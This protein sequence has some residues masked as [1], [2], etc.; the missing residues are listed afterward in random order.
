MADLELTELHGSLT[1]PALNSMNFLNEVSHHYPDA[2]SLAAGRPT[3]EFFALEDL[4]RYLDLFAD[5]LRDDRGTTRPRCGGRIFQYGRTKGIIHDLVARNLAVDEDIHVDPEAIVV[6]VGCQEAMFL[7]LRA[8]RADPDDVLLAVS[9][10]YVGLTGA[11]RLVDLPVLP[12]AGGA[13][14]V[15][16]DDLAAVVKA[17]RADGLRPRACY[18]MPD[19]ANPSGLSLGPGPPAA[20]AGARGRG[21]PAAARGQPVRPVPG[22]GRRPRADAEGAGHRAPGRLPRLVRQDRSA[23]R[24]G[25]LRRR[26]PARRGTGRQRSDCSPTN[27]RRSRAWSP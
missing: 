2:I 8:L 5:H 21:G 12:V 25:R 11:A 4:H 19:F 15:D 13:D 18:V 7:V 22:R 24:A 17:A 23:R 6:T 14:G 1:D 20:A 27:C 16:L 26:R 9:P 10:T 3:E